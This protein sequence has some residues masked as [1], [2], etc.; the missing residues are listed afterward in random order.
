MATVTKPAG[1][2]CLVEVPIRLSLVEVDRLVR[3]VERAKRSGMMD[4]DGADVF[5]KTPERLATFARFLLAARRRRDRVF[6]NVEFGEPAWDMLLDLYVQHVEGRQVCVS[7]LCAAAA[8]PA[9][10]A[11]RWI[12]MMV[13]EDIFVRQPDPDDGRRAHIRLNGSVVDILE[14]Y[15]ADMRDRAWRAIQ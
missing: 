12:D 13:R 15:L 10:T 8:V 7:S 9:T 14:G 1:E 4:A 2:D 11:L 3:V 6:P 5:P